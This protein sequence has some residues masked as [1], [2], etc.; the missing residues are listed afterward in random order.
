MQVILADD[1]AILRQGLRLLLSGIPAV[2][3]IGEAEN[4]AEVIK[5][6]AEKKPDV[7]IMDIAMPGV[8]GIEAATEIKKNNPEIK[9][10]ILSMHTSNAYVN[11]AIAAGAAGFILKDAAFGEL[12]LALEAI[13]QGTSFFSPAITKSVVQGYFTIDGR[14]PERADDREPEWRIPE[15]LT[16]RE[17]E[18]INLMHEGCSRQDIAD[19]LFI[20]CKT[21]DQHKG[22]I[23]RKLEESNNTRLLSLLFR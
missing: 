6:A 3:V 21:V 20:S 5:M 22:N 16:R 15:I 9:V 11:R 13:R 4:G 10:I 12:K 2:E 18:V 19:R 1:H 7:I 17:K 14:E 8:D 23:K